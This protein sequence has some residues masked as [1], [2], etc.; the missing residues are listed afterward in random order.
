MFTFMHCFTNFVLFGLILKRPLE[1]Q[2]ANSVLI[3]HYAPKNIF[4]Y[5]DR[6][7][8]TEIHRMT[9]LSSIKDDN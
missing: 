4:V 6:F 5:S 3:F 2:K 7:K 8:M 9:L 1:I